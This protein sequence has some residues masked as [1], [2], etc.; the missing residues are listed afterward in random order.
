VTLEPT[1][2]LWKK[3]RHTPQ[4]CLVIE[5]LFVSKLTLFAVSKDE[6]NT[7]EDTSKYAKRHLLGR[8]N[9]EQW[10][11]KPVALLFIELQVTEGISCLLSQSVEN[12]IASF[13]KHLGCSQGLFGLTNQYC[14]HRCL[15]KLILL[16]WWVCFMEYA[17]S[18]AVLTIVIHDV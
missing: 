11:I 14:S 5:I 4:L 18:L 16:S 9:I 3:Q 6:W 1:H 17:Y 2:I 12:S 13:W 15:G 7:K 10:K 8:S